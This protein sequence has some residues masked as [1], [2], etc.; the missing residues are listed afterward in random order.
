MKD[1]RWGAAIERGTVRSAEGGYVI[2]SEDRQGVVTPPLPS[3]NGNVYAAG[4]RVYFFMH[5]DG[6]GAVIG[7]AVM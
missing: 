1:E 4:D 6:T 2:A 7:R 5:E 3:L